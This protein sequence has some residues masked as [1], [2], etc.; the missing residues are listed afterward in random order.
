MTLASASRGALRQH[1][2]RRAQ[3]LLHAAAS[4]RA[5]ASSRLPNMRAQRPD[6]R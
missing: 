4:R 6:A 3:P 5:F 1:V 2:L